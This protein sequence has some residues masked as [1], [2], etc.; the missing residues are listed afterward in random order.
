M[1]VCAPTGSVG[2]IR[3]LPGLAGWVAETDALR[4][5]RGATHLHVLETAQPT[6][7]QTRLWLDSD[8]PERY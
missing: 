2:Q 6:L 7:V 1:A 3:L 8:S 4:L 5:A